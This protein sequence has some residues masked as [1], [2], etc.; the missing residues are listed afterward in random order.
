[1]GVA[2]QSWRLRASS[3]AAADRDVAG[4]QLL[5]CATS[6][7]SHLPQP[8]GEFVS[9]SRVV[10]KTNGGFLHPGSRLQREEVPT[11]GFPFHPC[12]YPAPTGCPQHQMPGHPRLQGRHQ[13]LL[14]KFEG[15]VLVAAVQLWGKRL[16]VLGVHSQAVCREGEAPSGKPEAPCRPLGPS[17]AQN[18]DQKPP[19]DLVVAAAQGISGP[20]SPKTHL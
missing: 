1:M 9:I 18:K 12:P 8:K 19:Q 14:V 2:G 20:P 10:F 4:K 6:L 5:C 16:W 11:L 15:E 13:Q 3:A 17:Q 7:V